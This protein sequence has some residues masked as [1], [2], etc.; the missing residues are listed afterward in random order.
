MLMITTFIA[1]AVINAT[2][3]TGSAS[4]SRS[5]AGLVLG[6]VVERC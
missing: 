5:V 6:A 1:S 3:P 2:A 4:S